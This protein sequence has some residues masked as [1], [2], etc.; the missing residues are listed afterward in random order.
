ML[1]DLVS[2]IIPAYNASDFL[3]EAIDS[4]LNQTYKNIEI[5]VINDGSN[6]DGLT[7]DIALAY[8]KS[9]R[10]Y[11]KENGGCASALNY[12]INLMNGDWFSWLSHDD[13]YLPNKIEDL[14]NMTKLP[15][16]INGK[17]ILCSNDLLLHNN[18]VTNNHFNNSLGLLSP[19]KAFHETLNVK[20]INGCGIL[21][22]KNAFFECGV[23]L[24]NYKHLLD[25][26]LWM[27]FAHFGYHFLFS[28]NK[29]VISRVHNN[30]ITV[31]AKAVLWSEEEELIKKYIDLYQ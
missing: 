16:F 28:H 2:I 5:I 8:G 14:L 11:E 24:T 10:Y 19:E 27:R 25:R 4:A 6:D 3:K 12:G 17:T 9:I 13:L 22:P 21:I 18:T 29:T 31:T 15:Q 30:Q 7:R 23:F 20:T 26:E 1:N